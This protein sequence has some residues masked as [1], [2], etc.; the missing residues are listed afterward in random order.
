MSC[1]SSTVPD[2]RDDV[3]SDLLRPF[4]GRVELDDVHAGGHEEPSRFA[5]RRAFSLAAA[6]LPL[7]AAV[8]APLGQT[9]LDPARALMMTARSGMSACLLS[10]QTRSRPTPSITC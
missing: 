10:S 7:V 3:A 9:L 4:G 2:L 8:R 6:G 1:T 5:E